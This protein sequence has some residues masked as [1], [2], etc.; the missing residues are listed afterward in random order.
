MLPDIFKRP[1]FP[2]LLRRGNESPEA[3]GGETVLLEKEEG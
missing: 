2:R 1:S 3:V